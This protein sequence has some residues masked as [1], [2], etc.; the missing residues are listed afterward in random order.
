MRGSGCGCL[1][2]VDNALV[3]EE[4][5]WQW[6]LVWLD[7]SGVM[8]GIVLWFCVDE[9]EAVGELQWFCWQVGGVGSVGAVQWLVGSV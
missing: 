5:V 2:V 6:A 8:D 7:A 4:G 3:G 1:S 9:A